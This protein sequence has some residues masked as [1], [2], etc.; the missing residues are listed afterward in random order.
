MDQAL[1]FYES[2]NKIL[3]ICGYKPKMKTKINEDIFLEFELL[4]GVGEHGKIDG[5]KLIEY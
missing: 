2:D 4:L 5:K 1:K 3:S